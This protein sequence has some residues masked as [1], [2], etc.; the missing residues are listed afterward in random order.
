M[1]T[2]SIIHRSR[3]KGHDKSLYR[4][5]GVLMYRSDNETANKTEQ[6]IPTVSFNSP[7]LSD[8]FYI[9]PCNIYKCVTYFLRSRLSKLDL[10][11]GVRA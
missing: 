11:T 8:L 9:V 4:D 7:R 10:N 2:R 3:I 5:T 6:K 1:I